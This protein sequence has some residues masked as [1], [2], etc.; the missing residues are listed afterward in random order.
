[1][2]E[3]T[4]VLLNWSNES[5]EDR[6]EVVAAL[7][8]D[9]RRHAARHLR[10]D[11]SALGL[12]PTILVNEAY[13]RLVNIDRINLQGRTHFFGL[14]GR[15]MREVLVDEARRLRAKKRDLALQTQLTGEFANDDTPV[16]DIL[17]ID[18]ILNGLETIDPVYV[19]LFEMRVFAGMTIEETAVALEI[20]T[21][22]V[23]RK[24]RVA[25]AWIKDHSKD[26]L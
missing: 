15:I 4:Q 7:Y 5:R 1:M 20:S 19:Q 14:S 10:K 2:A 8:E 18:E 25:V 6:G 24:W 11:G 13:M 9:L 23:K 17:E 22:T 12:Q 26:A 3:V 16:L 21:A